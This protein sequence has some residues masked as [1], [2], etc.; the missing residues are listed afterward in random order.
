MNHLSFETRRRSAETHYRTC[1][2]RLRNLVRAQTLYDSTD[3]AMNKVHVCLATNV[4]VRVIE[5][6][7]DQNQFTV[8]LVEQR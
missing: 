5:K 1:A 3:S 6:P 8:L 7:R 4:D 2:T